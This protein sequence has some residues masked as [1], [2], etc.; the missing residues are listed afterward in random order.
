MQPQFR[1]I[2]QDLYNGGERQATTNQEDSVGN[3]WSGNRVTSLVESRAPSAIEYVAG[4]PTCTGW[5]DIL[6]NFSHYSLKLHETEYRKYSPHNTKA[7]HNH[8]SVCWS[9]RLN[10]GKCR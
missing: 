6:T 3:R 8:T 4:E 9:Q 10:T 7:N 5:A 2:S 1:A